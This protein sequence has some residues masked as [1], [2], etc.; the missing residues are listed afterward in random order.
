MTL[1]PV[2]LLQIS[3]ALGLMA[4][5]GSWSAAAQTVLPT[6]PAQQPGKVTTMPDSS[7]GKLDAYL[8]QAVEAK[9]PDLFSVMVRLADRDG[10]DA[11][12]RELMTTLGLKVD[13]TLSSGRV[14]LTTLKVENLLDLVASDDVTRVSFDAVVKAQRSR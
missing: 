13:R 2:R 7:R 5:V 6:S 3:T 14:L 11:R 1:F 8:K 12:V 9:R 4:V 10:A